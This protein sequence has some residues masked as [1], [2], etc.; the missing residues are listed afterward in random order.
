MVYSALHG[1]SKTFHLYWVV[2]IIISMLYLDIYTQNLAHS[3]FNSYTPE[4]V[5]IF[6]YRDK[7]QVQM[8]YF[9]TRIHLSIITSVSLSS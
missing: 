9:L 6:Y 8:L 2:Y 7:T 5:P 4:R 3:W 1:M